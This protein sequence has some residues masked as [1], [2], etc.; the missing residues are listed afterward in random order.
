MA[1]ECVVIT[2]KGSTPVSLDGWRLEDIA[3]HSF[4]FEKAAQLPPGGSITVWTRAGQSTPTK[5]FLG[6]ARAIWNN[7]GDIAILRN[8]KGEPVALHFY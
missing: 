5:W 3:R 1:G 7:T 4:P 6:R 2:N 8:D